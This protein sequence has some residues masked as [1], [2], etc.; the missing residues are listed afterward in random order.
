MR[1]LL[2]FLI[3][4]FSFYFGTN[5]QSLVSYEYVGAYSE[6]ELQSMYGSMM[7]WPIEVYTIEYETNDVFGEVDTASG[8]VALP[9]GIGRTFPMC[10]FQHGTVGSKTEVPSQLDGGWEAGLIFGGLGYIAV[11]PDLLGLGSS[12]GFHPYLH[13]ESEASAAI[14]M[15][16]ASHEMAGEANVVVNSAQ[17]FLTGYSQGGHSASALHRE[18]EANYPDLPVR[19]A[20]H[21][22]G[23]YDVT[24]TLHDMITNEVDYL[25]PAYIPNI[26]LSYQYVYGIYDDLDEFFK[27]TYVP[28]IQEYRDGDITLWDLNDYLIDQLMIDYGGVFPTKVIKDDIVDELLNN[29]DHPTSMAVADNDLYDWAPQAPTRLI[30]CQADDQVSYINSIVADSVMN[31]NGAPD[32]SAFDANPNFDHGQC[33]EP[34]FNLTILFF[35]QYQEIGFYL[36]TEDVFTEAKDFRASPNPSSELIQIERLSEN[37]QVDRLQILDLTGKIRFASEGLP[38]QIQ[39]NDWPSGVYQIMIH[40]EK[41]IQTQKLVISR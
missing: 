28:K 16:Y 17:Y 19:A 12:R 4:V 40:T 18:L 27:P 9:I 3:L 2:L 7:E 20:T 5:A 38:A 41:G 11:L 6:L 34:A 26:A 21:M 33:V 39:V 10:V 25:T 15:L 36:N 1:K 22:S 24:G 32:L 23:P 30:Y 13:A 8:L 29:P 14:D 37:V 35:S 31:E